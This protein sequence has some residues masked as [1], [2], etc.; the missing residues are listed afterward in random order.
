MENYRNLLVDTG[1]VLTAAYDYLLF[2]N[3]YRTT[4]FVFFKFK[5][6][7][8]IHKPRWKLDLHLITIFTLYMNN[9]KKKKLTSDRAIETILLS[10][11]LLHHHVLQKEL[12]NH[13]LIQWINLVILS[14]ICSRNDCNLI[15]EE[16][17][18]LIESIVFLKHFIYIYI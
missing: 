7:N 1:S 3:W 15:S 5:G 9:N 17:W 13:S 12:W 11:C 8:K 4:T 16:S 18:W 10:V 2:R 14:H 6:K